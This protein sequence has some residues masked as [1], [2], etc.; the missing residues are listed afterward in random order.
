[1]PTVR[2]QA[3]VMVTEPVDGTPRRRS[4]VTRRSRATTEARI[5]VRPDVM[6]AARA[7]MRPGERL[8]IIY[9]ETCVE[10]RPIR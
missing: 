7:A 3:T 4:P 10:L 5:R 1:M 9:S 2:K 6:A 8:A